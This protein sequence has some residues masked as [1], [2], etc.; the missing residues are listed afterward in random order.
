ME[1]RH[2]HIA[3]QVFRVLH[4]L[5]PE[6]LRDWFAYAEDVTGITYLSAIAL[7]DL[8]SCSNNLHLAKV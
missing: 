5:C 2:F 3:I 7:L 4:K 8:L 6:Y 1:R